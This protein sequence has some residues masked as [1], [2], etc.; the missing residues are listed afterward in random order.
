MIIP[1][2]IGPYSVVDALIASIIGF[3]L[4]NCAV[5]SAEFLLYILVFV[6]RIAQLLVHP[7]VYYSTVADSHNG[8]KE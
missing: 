3:K 7:L 8:A 2:D 5:V 6:K 1:Q 4:A